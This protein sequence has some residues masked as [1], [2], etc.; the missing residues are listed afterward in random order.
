[1]WGYELGRTARDLGVAVLIGA[2]YRALDGKDETVAIKVMEKA[3][4]RK[5]SKGVGLGRGPKA[6]LSKKGGQTMVSMNILR[7]IAVRRF[8]HVR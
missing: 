4:L 3:E 1:M 6:P 7:E 2:V 5:K 8:A